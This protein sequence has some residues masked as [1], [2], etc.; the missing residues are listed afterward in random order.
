MKYVFINHKFLLQNNASISINERACRFGDGIFETCKIINGLIYDYKSHETRI[1]RGLK[2]LQ[3][4]FKIIDLYKNCLT[5]IAKNK[6]VNGVLRIS[7]SRGAGSMGYLP[8]E[9]ICPLLV[10]EA[11][12]WQIKKPA[13]IRIGFSKIK[14]PK[15]SRALQKCK[16]MQVLNYVLA[17][18][19]AKKNGHFDEILLSEENYISE[20]S[21]FNIF[22]LK[23]GKIYTPSPAC[24]ILFGTVRQK[25]I[26]KLPYKIHQIKARSPSILDAEEIF[27]TNS[28]HLIL[29]VDELCYKNKIYKFCKK[30]SLQIL[31]LLEEKS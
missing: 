19:N 15:R 21:S 20:C 23:A 14:A 29:P 18:I 6:I 26:D 22:W 16:T 8:Q 5:L 25:I 3:I 28:N 30:T 12:E 1:K 11:F 4:N 31:D 24:D 13:K 2:A 7:I 10:I 17:K 9:N 27:L